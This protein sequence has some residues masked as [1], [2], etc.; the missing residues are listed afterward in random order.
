MIDGCEAGV[1]FRSGEVGGLGA[2][3]GGLMAEPLEGLAR[4]GE[5]GQRRIA[6]LC[7]PARSAAARIGVFEKAV[8]RAAARARAEPS[9]LARWRGLRDAARSGLDGLGPVYHP[10]PEPAPTREPAEAIP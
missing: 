5:A 8:A 3:L 1:V 10:R 7:D 2:A 6:L 9:R 4:R